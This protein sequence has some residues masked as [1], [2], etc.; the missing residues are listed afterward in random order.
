MSNEQNRLHFASAIIETLRAIKPLILPV[1][2]ILLANNF[3]LKLFSAESIF[4]LIPI[5]VI[6]ILFF[7]SF[8]QGMIKW[9][10]FIYWIEDEQL[11]STSGLFVKKNRFIPLD[12]IQNLNYKEGI[13]HQVFGVKQISI[14]TAG[15]SGK[16]AEMEL[17]AI[18]KEAA[19][20]FEQLINEFHQTVK[21]H[22]SVEV[23]R[24]SNVIY[25][26]SNKDLVLLASTSNGIGVVLA[27]IFAFLSQLSDYIPFE[28]L[29]A[30]FAQYL[31]HLFIAIVV[32]IF[33][34]LVLAWAI[35]VGLTYL[36][37]YQFTLKRF[38]EQLELTR[39][40][41][42]KKKVT[43][44]IDKIQGYRMI[45]SPLRQLFGFAQVNI[46]IAGSSAASDDASSKV[47]LLPFIKKKHALELLE[48]VDGEIDWAIQPAYTSPHQAKRLFY[49][50]YVILAV[51][52]VTPLAI[53]V[54]P[55]FLFALFL[56]AA[57]IYFA[58]MQ[59]RA[60]AFSIK[61]HQL[62]VRYRNVNR[63]QVW[64]KRQ[65]IQAVDFNQTIFQK[66]VNVYT[67]VIFMMSGILGAKAK[68][69]HHDEEAMQHLHHWIQQKEV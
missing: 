10:T 61:D 36:A 43:I 12:R 48:K 58:L 46:E 26:M 7:V 5:A 3:Q 59:H 18:S 2:L 24:T 67:A 8:L 19:R 68:I 52:L 29:S 41:L 28:K 51:I 45:E 16:D 49:V 44:P 25:Q 40:L 1:L 54:S 32:M 27:G 39:G 22:E 65:K 37:N 38:D 11:K 20:Q 30:Q 50:K 64:M 56:F 53:F 63:I 14:E 55:Y 42:E 4:E 13:I 31:D 9:A 21:P 62:Y 57:V 33:I 34:A 66:R 47:L 35:S 6:I 69:L 23:V 60:A 15:S 17:T